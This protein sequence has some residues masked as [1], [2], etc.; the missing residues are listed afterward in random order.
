MLSDPIKRKDYDR[1][2]VAGVEVENVPNDS[3]D[4][5]HQDIYGDEEEDYIMDVLAQAKNRRE[6]PCVPKMERTRDIEEIL[7]V[8][9]EELYC[10]AEVERLVERQILC[11]SCKGCGCFDG[12]ELVICGSCEGSG[13]VN[14]IPELPPPYHEE[15]FVPP[16]VTSSCGTCGGDGFTF[17]ETNRCNICNGNKVVRKQKVCRFSCFIVKLNVIS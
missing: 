5:F 9:L 13:M 3:Y 8:S 10:E 12:S 2:G 11:R 1:M 16:P 17:E 7:E 15:D 6:K 4:F 14:H